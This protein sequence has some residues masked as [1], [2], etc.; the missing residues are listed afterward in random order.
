M[1]LVLYTTSQAVLLFLVVNGKCLHLYSALSQSAV[2][3][4]ILIYQQ[5]E[6]LTPAQ[7]VKGGVTQSRK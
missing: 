6:T 4:M 1:Q 3:L 2:Q 5:S 7:N